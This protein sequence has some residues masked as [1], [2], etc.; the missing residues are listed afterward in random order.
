MIDKPGIY[1]RSEIP[2]E[3]YHRDPCVQPSLSASIAKLLLAESPKHAWTAHPRLNPHYAE[4]AK[5]E[6]FNVGHAL[7]DFLL[8]GEDRCLVGDASWKDW[9]KKDAQK[10]RAVALADGLRP[11]LSE[12]YDRV[13]A[14]AEALHRGFA[15]LDTAEF[16]IPFTDGDPEQT[17]IWEE[18]G[19]IWCRA[20][21]DWLSADRTLVEDLKTTSVSVNPRRL[22]RSLWN[23]YLDVQAAFYRRGVKM[24][25]GVEPSFRFLFAEQQEPHAVVPVTL[26]SM[27]WAFAE[28]RLSIAMDRWFACMDTGEWPAFDSRTVEL[29]PPEYEMASWEALGEA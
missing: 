6:V 25:T 22:Q 12:Q 29:D 28:H 24:L 27:G 26:G 5:S 8:E 17:L 16:P 14:G 13:C 20:R 10:F 4:S 11:M 18:A 3:L 23:D 1:P 9:R 7:H 21:L 19:G 2:A 15:S